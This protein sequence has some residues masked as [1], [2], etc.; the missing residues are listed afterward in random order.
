M[1]E[2][3]ADAMCL[4]PRLQ[5]PGLLKELVGARGAS[6]RDRRKAALK[7]AYYQIGEGKAGMSIISHRYV[8]RDSS[9]TLNRTMRSHIKRDVR[10]KET[11]YSLLKKLT[12]KIRSDWVS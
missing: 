12:P 1:D 3:M 6:S 2:E 7:F 11:R 10:R 5:H 9:A 4:H 8:K